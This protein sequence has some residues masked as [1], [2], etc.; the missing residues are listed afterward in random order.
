MGHYAE[1]AEHMDETSDMA[2]GWDMPSIAA[3]FRRLAELFREA[4]RMP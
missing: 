1:T 4:D 2:E 3:R